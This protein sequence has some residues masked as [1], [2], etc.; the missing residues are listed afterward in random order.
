MYYSND[1]LI[2]KRI[3]INRKDNIYDDNCRNIKNYTDI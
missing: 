3:V 2:F 1:E